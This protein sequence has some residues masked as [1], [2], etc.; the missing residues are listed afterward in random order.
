MKAYKKHSSSELG[1]TESKSFF[2]KIK[3]IFRFRKKK[4]KIDSD[5]KLERSN[6]DDTNNHSKSHN[7]SQRSINS[8]T[9]KSSSNSIDLIRDNNNNYEVALG[10]ER[11]LPRN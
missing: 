2:S 5:T 10:Y 8:R 11:F 6:T 3:K 9:S 7:S 1:I 4:K